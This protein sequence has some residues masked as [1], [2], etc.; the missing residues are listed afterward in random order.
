MNFWSL[1]RYW[2]SNIWQVLTKTVR[3][4]Q[5]QVFF[6]HRPFARLNIN[7]VPNL[8][9]NLSIFPARMLKFY[10]MCLS[11]FK[12]NQKRILPISKYFASFLWSKKAFQLDCL[13]G[14]SCVERLTKFLFAKFFSSSV[15]QRFRGGFVSLFGFCGLWGGC[16]SRNGHFCHMMAASW[17]VVDLHCGIVDTLRSYP[18]KNF[19]NFSR[20]NFNSDGRNHLD[21]GWIN[22]HSGKSIRVSASSNATWMDRFFWKIKPEKVKVIGEKP[23]PW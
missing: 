16:G 4:L 10:I 22:G 7:S 6:Q 2:L 3:A 21:P 15:Q 11:Y 17:K 5:H 8:W 19:N 12:L 23:R 1:C 20:G 18:E 13:A 14:A 9:W